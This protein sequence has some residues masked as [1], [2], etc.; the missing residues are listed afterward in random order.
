MRVID[1]LRPH[2]LEAFQEINKMIESGIKKIVAPRATG[3]GKTYLM[4]ALAEQ[5]NDEKKL[6][7]EPTRPL[8]DSIKEKFDEF[9]IANTDFMTYQK[10][11]RISDEDIAA[12]DYK[13][14]FLDECH[15]STTPKWGQKIDCLLSTHSDSIIFGTSATTVRNDGVNVVETIF[16]GNAIGELPLS[17][18][19]ARKVLPCPK[20]ITAIYRLDD[21]LDKLRKKVENA[22]NTKAEKKEFLKKIRTMQSHFE[23]SYG[24]PLILNKYIKVKNGKYLVFCRDKEHLNAMRDVVIGWFKTAGIKDV[25]SYAVYSDYPDKEKD[26]KDFQDDKSDSLKILFSINM[27]NEGLHIDDI[28]GLLMLRTTQSN[29]IYL[30]QLGRLLEADNLDK[31]LL[32]FDFVNNFS[33][34]NDGIGLLK[35]I[36]GA[37]EREKEDNPDFDDRD[38][39]DIDTFF[40]LEQVKEIQELFAEIE[41]RLQGS[42]DL[43]IRAL[44]QFKQRVGDC[45]VPF[46]HIEMVDGVDVKLGH[47]VRSMRAAKK[48]IGSCLLTKEG[49]DQLNQLEFIWDVHK[50]R[51]EKNIKYISEYYKEHGE[52]PSCRSSDVEI[53]RYGD[54]LEVEK[55]EM[56]RGAYPKWKMK[57]IEEYLP[58]FTCETRK[59]KLFNEFMHYAKL[60]QDRNGNLDIKARDTIDGY[61]IGYILNNLNKRYKNNK[62]SYNKIK[63]LKELGIFLGDKKERDFMNKMEIAKLAVSDGIIICRTNMYYGDVDLYTWVFT[64]VKKKYK[65]GCLLREDIKV[66]ENL[67]GKSIDKLGVDIQYEKNFSLCV[68]A[69]H[70]G[71]ILSNSNRIYKGVNLV[72]WIHNNKK[73]FSSEELVIINQLM[74]LIQGFTQG[75]FSTKRKPIRI[76]DMNNNSS[77]EY[78]SMSEA[79]RALHNTFNVVDSDNKGIKAIQNHITGKIKNPVYKGRFRFEYA[80]N[81]S[82]DDKAN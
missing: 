4:G 80:D 13:L 43:Y 39:L 23:K 9:G 62:L 75:R 8:L 36:N 17:T 70:E 19:I 2:N 73:E 82:G 78:V 50:Y 61:N 60:Y 65:S 58:D 71:V 6:V 25:H 72:N 1:V 81:E 54:F 42:W 51:F 34:V 52:Y 59:N 49:E 3:S 20:Y 44:K 11:I 24:I 31:Y 63:Q 79:G 35:E 27:L 5:H 40:V 64:S 32:V 16:E 12:M 15:H 47:W 7:L 33:S 10:L 69:V 38:F 46:N 22:T 41:G 45:F 18:A 67:T 29:L 14:I 77:N 55:M 57:I 28:S 76:I 68:E 56:R 26:Y 66:I 21:E 48:G 37:I 30:Q 53:K 74:P